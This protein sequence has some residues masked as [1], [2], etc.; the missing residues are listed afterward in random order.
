MAV[1][2]G[3]GTAI[4]DIFGP[5]A[6]R[7]ERSSHCLA[8]RVAASA[9]RRDLAGQRRLDEVGPE[10]RG[11]GMV[12]QNDALFPHMTVQRNVGFGRADLAVIAPQF[13]K[14][15]RAAGRYPPPC[16]SPLNNVEKVE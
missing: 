1:P 13:V 16:V 8:P 7:A 11:F 5:E 15:A 9:E 6:K 10:N 14:Y 4:A 3:I 12:L 2:I